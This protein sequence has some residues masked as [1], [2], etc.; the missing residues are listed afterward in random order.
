L[1]CLD[2][3]DELLTPNFL[4]QIEFVLETD[5]KRQMLLFSATINKM[6][7][8]LVSKYM[9]DPEFIDLTDGDLSKR[10]PENVKH[11]VRKIFCKCKF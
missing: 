1:I 4:S 6:V 7:S 8:K 9:D 2:E 3:A 5:T 10:L 11:F